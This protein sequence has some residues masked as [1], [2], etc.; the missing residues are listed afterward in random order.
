MARRLALLPIPDS[1]FPIPDSRFP[2]P[3]SRFPI[4]DS[5]FPIPGSRFPI[6]DSRFPIPDSRFPI[7]GFSPHPASAARCAAINASMPL[8]ASVSMASSSSR[9]KAWPSAVPWISMMPPP[10]F[11]TTFMSVSQALSSA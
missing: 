10:S 2:I 7:P 9:R 1:R 8:P 3:D 4:P 5:R 6:P 11:I